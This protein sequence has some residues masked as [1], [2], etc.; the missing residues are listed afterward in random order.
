MED[1]TAA[2]TGIDWQGIIDYLSINAIDL[3]GNIVVALIIFYGGRWIVGLAVGA[4]R[5]V[6]QRQEVD[7]TLET[8]VCNLLRMALLVVVIIA[9][10][11]ALGI[12][13][14]SF[15]AI[16][17]AAG[18]PQGVFLV[19][20]VIVDPKRHRELWRVQARRRVHYEI[21]VL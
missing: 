14:A 2:F 3:A 7:K 9:A 5:K 10:I 1:I 17:G 16:F 21:A 11:S 13:T 6:M 18:L 4:L 19:A 15:I 20:G 12:Q 8:F